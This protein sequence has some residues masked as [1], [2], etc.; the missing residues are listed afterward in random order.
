MLPRSRGVD[1]GVTLNAPL[2]EAAGRGDNTMLRLLLLLLLLLLPRA[3]PVPPATLASLHEQ[4]AAYTAY[5]D[6]RWRG[7]GLAH[8]RGRLLALRAVQ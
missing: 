3:A 4:A 1:P 8:A 5:M 7:V 6:V 2:R